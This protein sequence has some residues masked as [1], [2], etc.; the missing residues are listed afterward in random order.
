[1]PLPAQL[2]D[3]APRGS[4]DSAVAPT[5]PVRVVLFTWPSDGMA[6]PLVSYKSDRSEAKGSGYAFARGLLKPRNVRALYSMRD[7]SHKVCAFDWS[8]DL[9]TRSM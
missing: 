5:Q 9:L 1:M 6:L 3:P 2:P 4:D 8:A 7:P